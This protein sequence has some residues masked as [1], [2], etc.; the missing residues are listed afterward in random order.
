V[1]WGAD[2]HQKDENGRTALMIA[3]HKG[4]I[5]IANLFAG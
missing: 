1:Q 4:H 5:E 3:K 2:V